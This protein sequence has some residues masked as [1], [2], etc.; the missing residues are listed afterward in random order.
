MV[1]VTILDFCGINT[2]I[3]LYNDLNFEL[4]SSKCIPVVGSLSD[5]VDSLSPGHTILD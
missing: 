1:L 5:C 3:C 4:S 2:K